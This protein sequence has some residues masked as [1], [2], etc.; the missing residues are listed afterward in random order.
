MASLSAIARS[1]FER[2]LAEAASH[3]YDGDALGRAMLALVIETYR[4]SRPIPD[5]Q[6][7]LRGAAENVDP[8]TDYM[9]MRP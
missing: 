6:A 9:F 3:G 1:H 4:Q 5:I 8:D 7:E 2:A